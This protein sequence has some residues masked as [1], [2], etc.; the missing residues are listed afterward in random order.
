M[1]TKRAMIGMHVVKAKVRMSLLTYR[2]LVVV[3]EIQMK[4]EVAVFY[5]AI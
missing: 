1:H 2:G 3:V 5:V 4:V